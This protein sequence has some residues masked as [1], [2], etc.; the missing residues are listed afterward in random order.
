[1]V[2]RVVPA[3]SLACALLGCGADEVAHTQIMVVVDSDLT[4]PDELDELTIDVTGPGGIGQQAVADLRAEGLPRSLALQR[5][6]GPLAPLEVR[7]LGRAGGLDVVERRA[8]LAFVEGR[9]LVLPMHLLRACVANSCGDLTCTESG[10]SELN[11]DPNS[12]VDWSGDEPRLTAPVDA[13]EPIEDAGVDAASEPMEA[14]A[15]A[16]V[17]AGDAGR[18]ASASDAGRDASSD[19]GA[20]AGRDAGDASRCMPATEVC[21]QRDDDCDGMSDEG[22]DLQGDERNCGS[23]GNVCS[24]G[25]MCCAG[26][27]GR[28]C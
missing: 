17:D 20:D 26:N 4:V 12:L 23:C 9:T 3:L 19:G 6:K 10:C 15:D 28:S 11:V 7:V 5:K 22:F 8:A 27:C 13:G 1:M 14:G 21:N 2:K 16:Q 25:R 24:S 18:D